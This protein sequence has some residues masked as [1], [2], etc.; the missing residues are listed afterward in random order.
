M[1]KKQ[2]LKFWGSLTAFAIFSAVAG[3]RLLHG[4]DLWALR[5][6]QVWTT[7]FLDRTGGIFSILGGVEFTIPAFGALVVWLFLTNGRTLAVHLAIALLVTSLVELAMKMWLPQVP[8]PEGVART[9]GFSPVIDVHYAYPYPSGHML[10]SVLLLGAIYLLWKNKVARFLIVLALIGMALSRIYL[11][12]HWASDVIG[13]TV[14]GI[15]GLVWAFDQG[16]KRITK[17]R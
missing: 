16:K 9:T 1:K 4:F 14:L 2:N 6:S 15:A 17:W 7:S 5:V 11:G 10:R 3:L 8:M 13:G 12:V